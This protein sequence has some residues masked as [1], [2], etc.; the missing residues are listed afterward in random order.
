MLE[1]DA[2]LRPLASKAGLARSEISRPWTP[3]FEHE[4]EHNDA[5]SM[6]RNRLRQLGARLA[7]FALL[8]QLAVSFGHV[9]VPGAVSGRTPA[10]AGL[11]TSG[12]TLPGENQVPAGVPDDDCP[13]C[14]VM[15][16]VAS[17]LLPVL[18]WIFVAAKFTEIARKLFLDPFNPGFAR[19]VLFQTRAPPFA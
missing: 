18:A 3:G 10:L 11:Q 8:V 15:H 13:I 2:W 19:H 14:A 1:A 12:K 17:G 6:T 4:A 7:L 16:L 9:H 5:G